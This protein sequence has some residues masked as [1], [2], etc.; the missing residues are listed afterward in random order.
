MGGEG[1]K[2]C[3]GRVLSHMYRCICC[4]SQ[5]KDTGGRALHC[6]NHPLEELLLLIYVAVLA[7]EEHYQRETM[8]SVN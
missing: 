3:S 4:L 5:P 1:V 2:Q 6:Y 8:F 7:L